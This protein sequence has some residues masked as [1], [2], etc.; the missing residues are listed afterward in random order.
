MG[1]GVLSFGLDGYMVA[2]FGLMGVEMNCY[3]EFYCIGRWVQGIMMDVG[4][5]MGVVVQKCGY[6][7]MGIWVYDMVMWVLLWV[8]WYGDMGVVYGV[9]GVGYGN[10]GI[11]MDVVVWECGYYDG[12]R[13]Q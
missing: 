2:R 6:Y 9:M 8:L 7:G 1:M 3:G 11:Q 13:V 5:M 4:I 10:V 12:C